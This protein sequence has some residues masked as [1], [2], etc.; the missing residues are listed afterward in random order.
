MNAEMGG[1]ADNN[2]DPDE[3]QQEILQAGEGL[4]P[5]EQKKDRRR[6]DRPHLPNLSRILY[7]PWQFHGTPMWAK[8]RGR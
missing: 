2:R 3:A 7:Q 8:L 5:P 6:D 1:S 4:D